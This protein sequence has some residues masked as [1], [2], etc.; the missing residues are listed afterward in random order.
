MTGRLIDQNN[1]SA[2]FT[3]NSKAI[4]PFKESSNSK[5]SKKGMACKMLRVNAA[6]INQVMHIFSQLGHGA[7]AEV[8]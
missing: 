3:R 8:R 1:N 2:P 6:T 5:A 7:V 4:V